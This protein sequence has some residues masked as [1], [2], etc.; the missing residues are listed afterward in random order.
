MVEQV[1]AVE[2]QQVEGD[3]YDGH[4][5]PH[6]LADLL[7]PKPPLELE[8]APH[9][10]IAVRENLAVHD[11]LVAYG[12]GGISKLGEGRRRLFQVAREEC[13]LGASRVQ[14][15]AHAVVLLLCPDLI[16]VS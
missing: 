4:L 10:A 13:D 6:L 12:A 16:R 11:E 15:A 5:A 3:Q 9:A 7:A 8:E 1:L 14:L 2:A